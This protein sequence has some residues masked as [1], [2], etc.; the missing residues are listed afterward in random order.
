MLAH[1]VRLA[2]RSLRRNPYLSLLMIGAIAV[3]ITASMIAITMYHAA[4]GSSHPVERQHIVC[5]DPGPAG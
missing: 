4:F 5:R 3:G 2:L 1:D